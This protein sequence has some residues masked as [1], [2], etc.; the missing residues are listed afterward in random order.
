MDYSWA[1]LQ[2]EAYYYSAFK[3]RNSHAK[4]KIAR[5][6]FSYR[7]MQK[8]ITKIYL[9]IQKARTRGD[10]TLIGNYVTDKF[11]KRM[12]RLSLRNRMNMCQNVELLSVQAV[13]F[14]K[15]RFF[16]KIRVRIEG[17]CSRSDDCEPEFFAQYCVFIR[18]NQ[19]GWKLH[20][21]RRP[22]YLDRSIYSSGRY[23]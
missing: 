4:R 21:V 7:Q 16:E 22:G 10:L 1:L 17:K 3:R 2:N 8:D 19:E 5:L 15:R 14:K 11:E 18:N 20:S 13:S 12:T 9:E 23:G 6:G